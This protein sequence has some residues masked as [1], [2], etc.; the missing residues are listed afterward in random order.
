MKKINKLIIFT[1]L[2]LLI[3]N[4]TINTQKVKFKVYK[5]LFTKDEVKKITKCFDKNKINLDCYKVK[6]T[7]KFMLDKIKKKLN[8]SY[9]N[10]HH[11]RYSHGNKNF[12]AKAFHRDIKPSPFSNFMHKFPNVY[13]FICIFDNNHK[14]QQGNQK[15]TLN[16]GDCLLFNSFN[17]H[18]GVNMGHF[19]KKSKRRILQL[20]NI[21]FDPKEEKK[22]Y[23][24]HSYSKHLDSDFYLKNINGFFREA[25]EYLCL[26]QLFSNK[27]NKYITFYDPKKYI[28]TI[29]GI[30][31]Y[32]KF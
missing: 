9:L 12:D 16:A 10:I 22:F 5:K 29:D 30:K 7:Q 11:A 21:F 13:T 15:L 20:F 27:Y 31:Y 24:H 3:L 4:R 23:K 25:A 14:H 1:I 18:K 17:L 32:K 19:D 8:T 2:I 28:A 6:K 26:A